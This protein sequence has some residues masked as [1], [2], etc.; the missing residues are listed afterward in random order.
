MGHDLR[1]WDTLPVLSRGERLLPRDQHPYM[2]S[3]LPKGV[4]FRAITDFSNQVQ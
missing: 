2:L 3:A 4:P 1:D